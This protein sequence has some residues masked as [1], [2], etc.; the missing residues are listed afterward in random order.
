MMRCMI[1]IWHTTPL[2]LSVD[3]GIPGPDTLNRS[4]LEFQERSKRLAAL[5]A[6]AQGA[7][8]YVF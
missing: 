7:A 3:T 2:S 4:Q 6:Q 1:V 5:S 8:E